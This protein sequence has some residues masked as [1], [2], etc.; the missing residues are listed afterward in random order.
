M[1]SLTL[2]RLERSMREVL[3]HT[4][5]IVVPKRLRLGNGTQACSSAVV[6]IGSRRDPLSKGR[7]QLIGTRARDR[8]CEV[9]CRSSAERTGSI[10]T[11]PLFYISIAEG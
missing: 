1:A 4:V 5:S 6:I 8:P 3:R 7:R 9:S 11:D 10:R 2:A